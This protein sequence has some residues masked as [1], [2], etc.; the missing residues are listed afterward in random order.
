[1]TCEQINRLLADYLDESLPAYLRNAFESHLSG[2]HAC[3]DYLQQYRRI[4]HLSRSAFINFEPAEDIPGE[5]ISAV[6][7][8]CSFT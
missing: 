2:C 5:L 1:V 4:V 8:A 7:S 6:L 3:R